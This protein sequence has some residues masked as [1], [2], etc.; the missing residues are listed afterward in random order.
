MTWMTSNSA[1]SRKSELE[2]AFEEAEL[3]GEFQP[4]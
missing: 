1:A 2:D 4:Q 3:D